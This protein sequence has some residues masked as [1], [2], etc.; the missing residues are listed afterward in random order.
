MLNM[1]NKRGEMTT[2]TIVAIA[3]GIAV[4]AFL[5]FGFSSGWNNLWERVV[6]VGGTDSNVDAVSSGCQ[7]ACSGNNRYAYCNQQRDVRFGKDSSIEQ[8]GPFTCESLAE[9]EQFSDY[10]FPECPSIT[11]S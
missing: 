10:G 1:D 4:L 7:V 5:I 11:C 3:L 6:N 8:E 2:A 9:D